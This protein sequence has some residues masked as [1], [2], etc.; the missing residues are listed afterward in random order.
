MTSARNQHGFLPT[1][2]ATETV[3]VLTLVAAMLAISAP[4]P[5]SVVECSQ[6]LRM[7]SAMSET[8]NAAIR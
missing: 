3:A 4:C 2:T 8:I 5:Q 7:K 1:L 6:Y